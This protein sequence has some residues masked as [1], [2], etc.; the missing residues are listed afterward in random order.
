LVIACDLSTQGG[1]EAVVSATKDLDVGMFI[2]AAGFGTSGPVLQA[3]LEQ[4]RVM[5]HVNCDA[6][7]A[8]CVHF[9]Q[10]FAARGRVGI[11]LMSSLVG[12]QGTPWAPQYTAKK[13]NIQ[14]LAE[15]MHAEL[16][17]SGVDVLASAPGPVYSGFA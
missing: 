14:A 13:V 9:G 7:L 16:K 2:A 5:L 4:E 17:P 10:R 8:H 11:I 1:R 15:A 3:D 6:P 12:W